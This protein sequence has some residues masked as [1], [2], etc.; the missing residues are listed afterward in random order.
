M[1]PLAYFFSGS[2]LFAGAEVLGEAEP[3]LNAQLAPPPALW[4]ISLR[5]IVQLRFDSD[6]KTVPAA[7]SGG[8]PTSPIVA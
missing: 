7:P 5:L 6:L 4:A 1:C 2:V 3:G 8:M